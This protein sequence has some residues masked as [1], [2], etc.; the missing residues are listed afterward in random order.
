MSLRECL[1][2]TVEKALE[3]LVLVVLVAGCFVPEFAIRAGEWLT[4][5]VCNALGRL[6]AWLAPSQSED[7]PQRVI[8]PARRRHGRRK[9]V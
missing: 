2:A 7:F 8:P 5:R 3:A 6:V 4:L 9:E 1:A